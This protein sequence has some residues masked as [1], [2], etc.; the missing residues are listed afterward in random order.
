MRY[1]IDYRDY[2][3]GQ[4]P[5][6]LAYAEDA[7]EF[8]KTI[9]VNRN[10][11]TTAA[12]V[13][14]FPAAKEPFNF[15]AKLPAPQHSVFSDKELNDSYC[16]AVLVLKDQEVLFEHYSEGMDASSHH[17]LMSAGKSLSSAIWHK[18]IMANLNQPLGL[19]LPP[20]KNPAIASIRLRQ[21]LD[22]RSPIQW[23]EDLSP[24]NRLMLQLSEASGWAYQNPENHDLYALVNK[25]SLAKDDPSQWRYNSVNTELLGLIG[26]QICGQHPYQAIRDF[27]Q[28]LGTEVS[29]SNAANLAGQASFSGSQSMCLRDFAKLGYAMANQGKINGQTLLSQS[30]IDDV[31]NAEGNKVQAWQQGEFKKLLPDISFYSHHW[32]VI[33]DDIAMAFGMFGQYLLFNRRSRVVVAKFSSY[34]QAFDSKIIRQ[35]CQQLISLCRNL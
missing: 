22:M 29:L 20:L 9:Y 18:P 5:V 33:D 21:L 31:F 12:V 4:A 14:N 26:A 35:D 25:L 1:P 11:A 7:Y 30:Y 19:F 16:D 13:W 3:G 23:S 6:G 32:Y 28:T 8:P 17:T 27:T 10:L 2:I 34:P 24:D 15:S